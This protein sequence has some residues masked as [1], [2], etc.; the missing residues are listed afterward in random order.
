MQGFQVKVLLQFQ[1]RSNL[2]HINCIQSF[3]SF[4]HFKR[5]AVS[6]AN[7]IDKTCNMDKNFL[8]GIV[9]FNE[10]ETFGRVKEFNCACFH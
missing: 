2:F 3:S 8:F 9:H 7:L 6:F 1:N 4:D 5:N 10:T